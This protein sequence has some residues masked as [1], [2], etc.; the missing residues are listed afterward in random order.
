[1]RAAAIDAGTN[2]IL[3]L[4][5]DGERILADEIEFARLGE[6]VDRTGRLAE[7]A[8]ERGLSAF[9]RYASICADL[10]VTRIAATGTSAL[11]DAA[12]GAGFLAR[13]EHDTGIRIEILSGVR[14]AH[15]GFASATD[16]LTAGTPAVVLDIGGGSLQLISGAA[17]RGV[18]GAVS[19]QLGAVRMT[20]RHLATDPPTDAEVALLVAEVAADL[21]KAPDPPAGFALFGVAGTCTTLAAISLGLAEYDATRVHGTALP[22]AEIERLLALF[23]GRTAAQRAAIPGLHP[24]R[25]DVIVAGTLALRQ[26]MRR[27]GAETLHVADRGIRHAVLRE[28]LTG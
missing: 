14:E 7:G 16:E 11:R 26:V 20:E 13:V 17:R 10:G 15:L 23:R 19:F 28:L 1:V 12:N 21:A 8:M 22:L 3:L 9:R 18:T 25:A 5:G 27:Y 6:G 4:A 2:T 24:R